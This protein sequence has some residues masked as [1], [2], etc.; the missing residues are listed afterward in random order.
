M[1]HMH[2]EWS[3]H[4]LFR[5]NRVVRPDIEDGKT[6]WFIID[7]KELVRSVWKVRKSMQI[8]FSD[9][10]PTFY[11]DIP[12]KSAQKKESKID[13]IWTVQK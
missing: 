1:Y 8:M 7:L 3:L 6:E 11:P 5:R 10:K 12:E 9:V 2:L 4:K 13:K